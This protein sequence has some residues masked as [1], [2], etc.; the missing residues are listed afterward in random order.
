MP[1]RVLIADDEELERRALRLIL[2]GEGMPELEILEASN[3]REALDLVGSGRL[4]AAFLD[5]R[6]PGID[7]IEA[8]RLLRESRP[9]LPIVFLTAHDSFEYAR[10]ALRLRVEDFLLKP[11][12]AE[13]VSA[14]LRRALGQSGVADSGAAAEA[15]AKL[16]DAVAYM[17][18][19]LRAD[20]GAG[21]VAQDRVERYLGLAG[22]QGGVRAIVALKCE[23]GGARG[24]GVLRAAAVIAERQLST[25]RQAA[26]AGAGHEI[27]LCAVLGGAG[28]A[29]S[30]GELR[31]RIDAVLAA[32]REGLGSSLAA[33]AAVP[34]PGADSATAM[35]LAQAA[36]RAAALAGGQRP[37]VLLTLSSSGAA[38]RPGEGEAEGSGAGRRTAFRALELLDARH[39]E[40]LSLEIVAGELGVSPSHLSRLLGRY[41]GMGFAD[42]L[43]RLRVERAKTYL[44]SSG[45]SIKE[46]AT[47]VGFRDPAY[48]ARV[49]RRFEGESPAEFRELRAEGGER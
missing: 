33:G 47:M 44:L 8:A 28:D 5:I 24:A 35:E 37:V 39:A 27:A 6:M 29:E 16:V 14:A 13:E 19:E 25:G 32:A 43:A 34:L 40:E 15:E 30:E 41:A 3:G 21:I 12:S 11:A 42:C 10:S 4:D 38:S 7:G 23:A 20:L 36:L 22:R 46:A 48:F 18:G 2:G 31:A 26:L 17:A 45:L 1:Y 49:F 9:R